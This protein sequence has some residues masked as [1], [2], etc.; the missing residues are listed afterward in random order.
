MFWKPKK[1][2]VTHNGQF[3]ADDIFAVAVLKMVFGKSHRIKIVR[4]RD[5]NLVSKAD[6]VVDVGMEYNSA[7]M[8][9]DHHQ[10]GGAGKR[11][12]GIPYASFGLVWKEF[13]EKICGDK[14]VAEKIDQVLVQPVDAMDNGIN[15]S[16]SSYVGIIDYKFKD[17]INSFRATWKEGDSVLYERFVFLVNFCQKVLEREIK[18]NIDEIEGEKLVLEEYQKQGDKRILVLDKYLPFDSTVTNKLPEI[19]VIIYPSLVGNSWYAET[20][21]TEKKYDHRFYFPE[22]WAGKIDADLEKVTGLSDVTFCH[23]GKF[24][25]VAQTKEA[26]LKLIELALNS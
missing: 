3:H 13:G 14:K 17:A 21:E 25:A 12:N 23:H 16:E 1:V 15:I 7:K 9:F 22:S 19:L 18:K 6:F 10:T 2:I 5:V 20:A 26:I 4:T 11:E 24:L 8:R